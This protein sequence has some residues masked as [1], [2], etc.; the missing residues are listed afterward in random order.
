MSR[1]GLSSIRVRVLVLVLL[2]VLPALALILWTA[3]EQRRLDADNALLD[4][5]RQ[6]VVVAAE[7]SEQVVGAAQLLN[8]LARLPAMRTGDVAACN[9]LLGRLLPQYPAYTNITA[10]EPN[11]GVRCSAPLADPGLSL[12]DRAYFQRALATDGFAAGD[13]IIGRISG[14]PSIDFA[15]P[16]RDQSGQLQIILDLGID[17]TWLNNY[18][19]QGNWPPGTSLTLLDQGGT[20]VANYPAVERVG[21]SVRDRPEV[22][23]ALAEREGQGRSMNLAGEPYLFGYA[24]TDSGS[25]AAD[26]L[27]LVGIPEAVA[28]GPANRTLARNLALLVAVAALALLAGWLLGERLIAQPVRRL[29]TSARRLAAGDLS[30]RSGP[31]YGGGELGGLGQSFDKMAEDIEGA[32]VATV[33]VLAAAVEARDSDRGGHVG[34]VADVA[35]AIAQEYGWQDKQLGALRMAAALHDVGKVGVPDGVLRKGAALD[36]DEQEIVRRHAADGARL[37]QTVSFLHPA[38]PIVESH[39]EFYDGHGYPRGIARDEIPAAARIVAVADAFEAITAPPPGGRGLSAAEAYEEIHNWAYRQF[40]PEVVQ[41][42][43]LALLRGTIPVGPAAGAARGTS[44]A[45]GE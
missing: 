2:A 18:L 40:D 11:G 12:A 30:A 1:F 19:A 5:R 45:G 43:N 14:K 44:R 9:A 35:V 27:V 31:P 6:A 24:S 32:Y 22:Q 16:V 37:L 41:A 28:L 29:V 8:L 13:F 17:L 23:R 25:P 33:Q 21:Q 10:I 15:Q 3:A 26:V 7:Q 34:R 4:A 20:I 38:I 36:A 42:L 39:H